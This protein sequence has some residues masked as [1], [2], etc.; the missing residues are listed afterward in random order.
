VLP[1]G[2]EVRRLYR[3]AVD[4]KVQIRRLSFKRDSLEEIFLAAMEGE[5]GDEAV[6]QAV[7][8]GAR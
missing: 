7:G 6:E 4:R 1:D 3:E 2:L 5:P 8:G